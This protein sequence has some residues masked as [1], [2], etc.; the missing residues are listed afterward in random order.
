MIFLYAPVG[1]KH[2]IN[3]ADLC[4]ILD[5]RMNVWYYKMY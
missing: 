1:N 3:V 5:E 4:T 2:N